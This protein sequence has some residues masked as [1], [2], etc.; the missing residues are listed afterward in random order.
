MNIL[1]STIHSLHVYLKTLLS[2]AKLFTKVTR[3]SLI[4]YAGFFGFKIINT[5]WHIPSS[6]PERFQ[7][8]TENR[9]WLS[10][11]VRPST[12]SQRKNSDILCTC[13]I[14]S[15]KNWYIWCIC[16]SLIKNKQKSIFS[17]VFSLIVTESVRSRQSGPTPVS[18]VRSVVAYA[19]RIQ[20]CLLRCLVWIMFGYMNMSYKVDINKNNSSR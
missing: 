18:G 7:F 15:K 6:E 13:N 14:F 1:S 20:S 17:G 11:L 3:K 16:S 12:W 10:D 2:C 19:C 8:C 9:N 4:N 5:L